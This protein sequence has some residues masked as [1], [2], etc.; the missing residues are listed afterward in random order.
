[1]RQ[2]PPTTVLSITIRA[3]LLQVEVTKGYAEVRLRLIA[4]RS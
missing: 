1:M 4:F 2:V 3:G